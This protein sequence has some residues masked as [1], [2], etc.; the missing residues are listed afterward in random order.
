MSKHLF[1]IDYASQYRFHGWSNV[2]LCNGELVLKSDCGRVFSLNSAITQVR[3][4]VCNYLK[5]DA[6]IRTGFSVSLFDAF[7][8]KVKS[9][10]LLFN[11]ETIWQ[12]DS[13]FETIENG[14]SLANNKLPFNVGGKR[15]VVVYSRGGWLEKELKKIISVS[16]SYFDKAYNSGVSYSFVTCGFIKE[17][18]ATFKST[19]KIIF[20]AEKELVRELI[21]CSPSIVD[22]DII[23]L[24]FS[25]S[26]KSDFYGLLRNILFVSGISPG[27][28]LNATNIV[29]LLSTISGY[30]DLFFCVDDNIF[31]YHSGVVSEEFKKVA[32]HYVQQ[33]LQEDL[34]IVSNKRALRLSE[35]NQSNCMLMVNTRSLK[36]FFDVMGLSQSDFL[37]QA[38]KRGLK[39]KWVMAGESNDFSYF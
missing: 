22:Q 29:K 5:V 35:V 37:E 14:D 6:T 31:S 21:I 34:V 1:H 15:V 23:P 25:N 4:D 28:N 33:R 26:S 20:L 10:K 32:Q 36:Y 38:L 3:E 9:F 18:R 17:H 24:R 39:V 11:G 2:N 8:D 30:S 16:P 19:Q 27:S 12:L 7:N 13:Y